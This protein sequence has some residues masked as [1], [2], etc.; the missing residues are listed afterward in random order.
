MKVNRWLY[1]GNKTKSTNVCHQITHF[2]TEIGI[3]QLISYSVCPWELN[4]KCR[5]KKVEIKVFTK[6]Q[7]YVEIDFWRLVA[8]RL[9]YHLKYSLFYLIFGCVYKLHLQDP[10]STNAHNFVPSCARIV[11]LWIRKLDMCT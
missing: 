9:V 1:F 4:V 10:Y 3:N 2:F 11:L 6:F 5:C 7:V 8:K